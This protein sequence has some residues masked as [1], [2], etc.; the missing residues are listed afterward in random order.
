M[1]Y[2]ETLLLASDYHDRANR[3]HSLY[4]LGIGKLELALYYDLKAVILLDTII[5]LY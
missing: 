1:T 5:P 2:I 4:L 3:Q